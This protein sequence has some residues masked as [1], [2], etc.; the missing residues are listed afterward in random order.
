MERLH[1]FLKMGDYP[2]FSIDNYQIRLN[3]VVN[4]TLE[5][6]IPQYA[7]MN[8]STFRCGISA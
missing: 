3:N 8:V 6:D 2:F 4:Q 1:K 5:V 7:R